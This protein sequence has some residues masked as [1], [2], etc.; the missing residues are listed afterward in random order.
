MPV[1]SARGLAK[2]YGARSLFEDL[3]LTIVRGEC[4]GL[5]GDN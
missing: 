2:A 3:S 1:L 5:L 4:V